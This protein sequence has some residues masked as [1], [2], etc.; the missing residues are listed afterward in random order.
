M[1]DLGL[2]I[3]HLNQADQAIRLI[4]T[5]SL[6]AQKKALHEVHE[7]L[8]LLEHIMKERLNG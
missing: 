2:V 7:A 3:A 6:L 5:P 8:R 4:P 1:K